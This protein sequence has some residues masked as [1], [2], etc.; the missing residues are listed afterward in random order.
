VKSYKDH[1]IE[2]L[3]LQV[4]QK[5]TFSTIELISKVSE[6]R[7]KT[8]K[9]GVYRVLRKLKDEEKILIHGK[10]VSLNIQ[11]VKRM[12]DFFSLA[13]FHYSPRLGGSDNFL[14]LGAKDKIVYFFKNLNLLDSFGSHVLHM[15]DGV[16]SSDEPIFAYNPHEWFAYAREEAEEMLISTFNENKR[17]VLVTSTYDDPLDQELK[18]RFNNDLLQYH[19]STELFAGKSNYYFVIFGD[20][21]IEIF[22]DEAIAEEI[23][24]FYKRTRTFDEKA[25]GELLAV[26]SKMGRNRLVISRQKRKIES[27]KKLLSK[28]FYIKKVEQSIQGQGLPISSPA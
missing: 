16:V 11:W 25:R 3:V 9:Q 27:Y 8:T 4:L 7:S 26:V 6:A 15:L 19:I 28:N 18:R 17:A 23:N 21:L 24:Q 20:Y 10:S 1:Q 22:I 2:D 5:G 13:Q 14:N 12:G